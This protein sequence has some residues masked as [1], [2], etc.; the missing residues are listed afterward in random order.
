MRGPTG[1]EIL[2]L[3]NS[4]HAGHLDHAEEGVGGQHHGVS[5]GV[6]VL[7]HQLV[8]ILQEPHSARVLTSVSLN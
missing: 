2:V 8:P 7:Q 3:Q 4:L 6:G 5:V 1:P